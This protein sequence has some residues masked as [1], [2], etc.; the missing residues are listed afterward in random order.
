MNPQGAKQCCGLG[1]YTTATANGESKDRE[2]R[3]A[4]GE[5]RMAKHGE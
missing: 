3:L 5:W 4:N 1:A 2:W